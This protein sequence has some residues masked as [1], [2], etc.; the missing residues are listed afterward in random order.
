MYAMD[1]PRSGTMCQPKLCRYAKNS[2]TDTE[3]ESMFQFQ[4]PKNK[5]GNWKRF[6]YLINARILVLHSLKNH[7]HSLI[8]Q[9]R[10]NALIESTQNL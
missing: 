5:F 6:D 9:P 7:E 10:P 2:A 4:V 1:V 3:E 8:L